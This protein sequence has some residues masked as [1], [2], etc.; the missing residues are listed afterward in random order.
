MIRKLFFTL[1]SASLI[2]IY[3]AISCDHYANSGLPCVEVPACEHGKSYIVVNQ[4]S[5]GLG[6][7]NSTSNITLCFD[8]TSLHVVHAAK[9]QK[10]LTNPGYDQCNDA[11][12]NSN[13]AEMFIAPNME[14][15]N[16]CYN[17]LDISPFDVMFDAGIYNPNL[18]HTTV[19]GSTFPCDGTGV[20]Y[21][22]SVDNEAETWTAEMSFSFE[23]L[24]CPFNCPLKEY[25]GHTHANNVYR[26][27]F[28]RINQLQPDVSSCSSSTCEYMAWNPTDVNP[29]AFHEP[30]KFGYMVLQL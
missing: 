5:N 10:Y 7:S 24:N 17:E 8:E 6:L 28:F 2:C 19:E 20:K 3:Q 1:V 29:P 22:T 30:S 18:N 13:V 26:V 16:H 11:I 23:L 12:F 27:N 14:K 9:K 25:C 21:T 4:L 15:I